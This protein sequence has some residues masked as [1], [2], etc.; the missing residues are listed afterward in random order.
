MLLAKLHLY[1]IW[2]VSEDWF[3]SCVTSR[4]QKGEVTSPDTIQNVFSDWGRLQHGVLQGSILWPLLFI[5]HMNDLLLRIYSVPEPI[6]F[7][8]DLVVLFQAET[9]KIFVQ[10]RV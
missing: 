8:D 2:G 5:L 7:A 3:R 10:C 6:L 4:G 1:G 9:S